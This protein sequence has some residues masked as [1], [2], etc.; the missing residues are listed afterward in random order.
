MDDAARF[1]ALFESTFPAVR[2]YV[3]HRGITG[4]RADDVVAETFLV[5]WRR[6]DSV[7]TD[8][9][10]PWLLAV[11]RNVCRN[12]RRGDR[13]RLALVRRLPA[14]PPVP[15]PEGPGS[16]GAVHEALA[17]LS[18]ADREVL[19]LVAWDGLSAAQ[20]GVVLG[21]GA[22]AVRVRLYRA[23]RRMAQE[24]VKRGAVCGQETDE[25]RS[26]TGGAGR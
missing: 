8:D 3:R 21:I 15:P 9:P 6:L 4:G 19:V 7:P 26:T 10:L 20:A 5:T 16:D 13:R 24:L 12:E 22:G 18:A 14:P 1:R 17:A 25:S 23:R 2:R 11:A